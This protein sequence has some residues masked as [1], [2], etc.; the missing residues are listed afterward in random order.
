[1]TAFGQ[2]ATAEI[3]GGYSYLRQGGFAQGWHS[4]VVI[5]SERAERF[6]IKMDLSGHYISQ[7]DTSFRIPFDIDL[8]MYFYRFGPQFMLLRSGRLEVFTHGLLGGAYLNDVAR[9]VT[10]RTIMSSNH[11]NHFAAAAGGGMDIRVTDRF[12]IR[13]LES[14]YSMLRVSGVTHNGVRASSGIVYKF[15]Y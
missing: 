8:A 13:I 3:F 7:T 1:M 2:S 15:S 9:A 4:S 10:D 6:G 12:A 5:T 14:D 11:R